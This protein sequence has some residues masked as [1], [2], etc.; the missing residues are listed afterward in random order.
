MAEIIPKE[1]PT[2][3][4]VKRVGA[5][6]KLLGIVLPNLSTI[7]CSHGDEKVTLAP[8]LAFMT[9][10]GHFVKQNKVK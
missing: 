2:L 4:M 10:A 7:F 9:F 5:K 1:V 8:I 6:W 3:L